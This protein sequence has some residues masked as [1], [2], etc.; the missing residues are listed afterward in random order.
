ML[1]NKRID[2]KHEKIDDK[3]MKIDDI[4]SRFETI[5]NK[6]FKDSEMGA[7]EELWCRDFLFLIVVKI[8]MSGFRGSMIIQMIL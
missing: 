7:Q 4:M 6:F 2:D 8:S 5:L 1:G 3:P